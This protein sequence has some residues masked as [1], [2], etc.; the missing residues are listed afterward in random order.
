M[1][2]ETRPAVRRGLTVPD[3][4]LASGALTQQARDVLFGDTQYKRR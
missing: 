1:A 3:P 4:S 2:G